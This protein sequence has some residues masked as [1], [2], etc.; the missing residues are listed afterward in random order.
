MTGAEATPPGQPMPAAPAVQP[1]RRAHDD[2]PPQVPHAWLQDFER[3]EAARRLDRL[4]ADQDLVTRLA[5][6]QYE[7]PEYDLFQTELAKYGLDVITGWLVRGVI[8]AKC[9]ERGF[10]GLPALPGD[11]LRDRDTVAGL[12]GKTVAKA[13]VHF[14]RD[15][16]LRGRWLSSRGATLKTFFVGQCLIRFAN[17]YRAWWT[18]EV[19][20]FRRWTPTTRSPGTPAP[21]TA[22]SSRSS[23]RPRSAGCSGTSRT[24]G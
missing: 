23:I 16:L 13:L 4:T 2:E 1:P 19:E 24:G 15:V 17:I 10:G 22:P 8:F 14:R 3:G 20:Q 7:G 18:R 5:L 9:K 11:S 6:Q 12:A 21:S